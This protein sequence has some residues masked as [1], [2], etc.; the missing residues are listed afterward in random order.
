MK[1]ALNLAQNST[2]TKSSYVFPSNDWMDQTF[3]INQ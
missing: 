1:V 3:A 2:A